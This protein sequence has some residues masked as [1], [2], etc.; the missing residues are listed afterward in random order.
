MD[1]FSTRDIVGPSCAHYWIDTY[2]GKGKGVRDDEFT[3]PELASP[4]WWKD[5]KVSSLIATVGEEETMRDAIIQWFDKFKEGKSKGSMSLVIGKKET[6]DGPLSL[7]PES[8]L[9]GSEEICTLAALRAWLRS[10]VA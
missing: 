3:C 10:N 2:K 9:E 5:A 1:H 6:H 8:E 4:S 7:K